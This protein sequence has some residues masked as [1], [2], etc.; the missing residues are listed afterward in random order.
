MR[1]LC[2]LAAGFAGM[3]V[4]AEGA[5]TVERWGRYEVTLNQAGTYDN[6]FTHAWLKCRFRCGKETVLVDGFYDGGKTWK[7]RFM[8]ASEGEWSYKTESN[9][10]GLDERSGALVC[11]PPSKEN[12]GPIVIRN[13]YHFAFADGT[14]CYPVGTTLYNWIHREETLQQETLATLREHAFNKVRFCTFPKWYRYNRVEPPLYP[15]PKKENGEF[16]RDRFNPAYF[17]H[18]ERRVED[19]LDMGII[20]DI[21]LFHPYD[22]DRWGHSKMSQAQDDA[23]LKYL[24]SRVAAYRNVWWTMANEYDL[25]KV[26]KD[27]DHIFQ[28]VRDLDPY[29][30]PRSNHNCRGWYDHSKPWVTHC[31][32]Q[33]GNDLYQTTLK[34][35]N[36]Y[37]KPVVI[38]EYRY[39]GDIPQGWGNR[40]GES[41]AESHWAI[42][43]GGG[44]GSHG[45]TY[46]NEEEKLWWA[47]GGRLIGTS[48][49]R[50][51][52]L[53]EIMEQTPYEEM[54]PK[55]DLCP[56][57]YVLCKPGAYYL[58]YF[59]TASPTSIKLEGAK[60][61]KADGIDTWNMKVTSLGSAK[62]GTFHFTPPKADYLLRLASYK[63]G[64]QLRPEA[65]A[66]ADPMEG[67]R[68]TRQ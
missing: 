1:S 45:E 61:Y 14:P 59:T 8:P 44:Y 63:P 50:I 57:N 21:I 56:G 30:H 68:R 5:E 16:D 41:E 27:W 55:P 10:P 46:Y 67:V 25:F 42:A 6:P 60:P 58:I 15:W 65:K 11:G 54:V 23:Y 37:K 29:G 52:F 19:L 66:S 48:P 24:I 47:V 2:L 62:P 53:K 34:A 17:K 20:A 35:R 40:T 3:V 39:E 7:I 49:P 43:L 26:K 18:I 33:H 64:E 51:A 9:D 4:S 12:H 36:T 38:D 28:A 32:I 22:N 31:N 13:T